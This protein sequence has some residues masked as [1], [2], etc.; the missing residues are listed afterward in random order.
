MNVRDLLKQLS[1]PGRTNYFVVCPDDLGLSLLLTGAL[2]PIAVQEDVHFH[3][4]AGISKEKARQIER[5]SRFAPRGSSEL[6]HFYIYGLQ[7]L[8]SQSTGPL[9]K[10]VEEA[11]YARFIFQSQST[12]RK[13]HT[14]MSRSSVVKLPFFSRRM[15]LGNMKALNHDAKT[16]DQLGLY[17]GT[18]AG[19]IRNLGMKDTLTEIRRY[20]KSGTRGLAAAYAQ[21]VL[22]SLAFDAAAYPVLSKEERLYLDRKKTP[23]RQKLALFLA[24]RRS[25]G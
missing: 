20:L 22:Q 24:L 6:T 8:P 14:L 9:L 21:D 3:D 19:S 1:S 2:S 15:V 10:A 17:D 16:A 4:A 18:L 23:E 7:D 13:V 11:R 25:N 12:P 5:E